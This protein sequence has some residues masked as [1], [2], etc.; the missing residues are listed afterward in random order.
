MKHSNFIL[1]W[2]VIY[3]EPHQWRPRV[4]EGL[5][6]AA[7]RLLRGSE[8]PQLASEQPSQESERSLEGYPGTEYPEPESL[9]ERLWIKVKDDVTA[10]DF[11]GFNP[12]FF[13]KWIRGNY[14][15]VIGQDSPFYIVA[16]PSGSKLHG[17]PEAFYVHYKFVF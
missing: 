1:D 4:G 3:L 16:D 2:K 5:G 13:D 15:Q 8:L 10:D 6:K 17:I 12:Q 7:L 9:P 11:K 14:L